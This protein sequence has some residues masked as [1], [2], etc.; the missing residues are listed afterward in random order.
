[1]NVGPITWS[2]IV[3]TI[4]FFLTSAV[5]KFDVNLTKAISIGDVPPDQARLPDWIGWLFWLHWA[6]IVTLFVLNWR[7]AILVYVVRSILSF[8]GIMGIVG[9]ILTLPIMQRPKY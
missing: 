4:A 7:L 5:T 3:V 2:S 8:F 9:G 1:M 6:L